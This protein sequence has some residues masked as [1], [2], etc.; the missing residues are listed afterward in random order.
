MSAAADP[1]P[2][3]TPLTDEQLHLDEVYLRLDELRA[4]TRGRL[5]HVRR[6]GPSGSPQN[7]SER[8]AF[9][10][11]YEDRL[12]QLESVEERLVFGRLDLTD[13]EERYVGRIGLSDAEHSQLLTD[14]RAPAAEPFYQA[15]A[16]HPGGVVLRRHIQTR[17]RSVVS[18]EDDVLDLDAVT[19]PSQVAGQGALLAALAQHRTGR[20]GDIVA[21]IQ[22]EQDAIIRSDSAGVLVVQGGPGTG[23]TAVALHRAAYL[24][25]AHRERLERSGVLVIGP[26]PVFLRYIEQ[27]L[28]ALGETGV[29]SMTIAG[30]LPDVTATGTEPDE[31]A[32]IKGRG[33]WARIL[34]RAVRARQRVL[35]ERPLRVARETLTLRPADLRAAQAKARRTGKPHNEARVTFVRHMLTA[36]AQQYAQALGEEVGEADWAELTEEVRSARDVRVA[37]NLAWMPLTPASLLRDLYTKPHRLL[38]AA[39][40]LGARTRARLAWPADRVPGPGGEWPE[41]TPADV[42]LLDELAELLGADDSLDREHSRREA[43]RRA[44]AVAY[45]QEM[46]SASGAG[47]GMVSAEMLA[48]RFDGGAA[49]G[50]LADRARADRQWTYGHVV[51][52]EAQELSAMAW[53]AVLRRNPSRSM[54]VVGDVAQTSTAAGARS[55]GEALDSRLRDGWRLETLSVN[56]RTPASIMA[57]AH[58]VAAA[59]DPAHPPATLT[60]ARD[61]EGALRRHHALDAP[62]TTAAVV[63]AIPA[64]TGAIAVIAPATLVAEVAR[65]LGVSLDGDLRDPVVV[66]T[67]GQAKGLEFDHV[68][69]VEPARIQREGHGPGDLYVAMTRPTRHLDVVHSE[70]LPAGLA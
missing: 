18:I 46:L 36:L 24:L 2:T 44:E 40:E 68:V 10:T 9:A 38:E 65:A 67:P 15:T 59:A 30:L 49:V 32:T 34:P 70:E 13:G 22:A 51:I 4:H 53:R 1:R 33:V 6:E 5:A 27:V 64:D 66:L 16:A 14:W 62:A 3:P 7:R 57:A 60:S 11:L 29:V 19:D 21:T 39:P 63:A 12:A 45:A 50:S 28:P 8:D 35:S 52:D 61:V 37:L 31:I 54:T 47:G 41:W 43:A 17:L 56:Y 55:W 25:Y 20:M 23:K 58:A 42:P 48:D 69:L 26:T